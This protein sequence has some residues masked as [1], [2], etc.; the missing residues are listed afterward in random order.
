MNNKQLVP[1]ATLQRYPVYLKAL[2]KLYSKGVTRVM[3]KELSEYVDIESTTIRRDFSFLGSLG[4]QGYGYDVQRL[5]EIFSEELGMSFDEKIIIVGSG[6]LGKALMNYNR[7]NYVV[8]EVVCGFDLYPEK[9]GKTP[10]PVYP[11]EQLQE[12]MPAGCRIAILC[13]SQNVQ[14]TVDKLIECG[15]IGL[16]DF[17]HEHFQVPK[18]VSVRPVDVVSMIQELVFETNSIKK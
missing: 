14:E 7:W 15:I 18:N 4:K 16:V 11:L 5:I 2:R 3:S 1:K 9:V 10:I 12:K 6:N 13:I 17:T 8:G